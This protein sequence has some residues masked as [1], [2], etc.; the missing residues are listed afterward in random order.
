[1][2]LPKIGGLQ[3]DDLPPRKQTPA[4]RSAFDAPHGQPLHHIPLQKDEDA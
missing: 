2:L 3:R 1:M 4:R